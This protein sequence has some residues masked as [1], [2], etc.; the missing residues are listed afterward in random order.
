MSEYHDGPMS[1]SYIFELAIEHYEKGFAP[2]YAA[3]QIKRIQ[4]RAVQMGVV[5]CVGSE[6]GD[7]DRFVEQEIGQ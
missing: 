2:G 4:A 3:Q 5:C 6:V 7:M 1:L